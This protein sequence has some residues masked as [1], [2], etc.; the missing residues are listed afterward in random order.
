MKSKL[1]KTHRKPSYYRL[2]RLG[3]ISLSL[4]IA[5][6]MVV[7]PLTF[8]QASQSS[9]ES[10]LSSSSSSASSEVASSQSEI[11]ENSEAISINHE[12]ETVHAEEGVH[13][14]YHFITKH[15]NA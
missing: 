7:V 11:V 4:M 10:S 12:G 15:Q 6:L 2:Q 5:T 13:Y 9:S 14:G 1:Y 3:Y 8:A